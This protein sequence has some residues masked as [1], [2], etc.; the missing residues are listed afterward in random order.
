MKK[1]LLCLFLMSPSLYSNGNFI[2]GVFINPVSRYFDMD[3]EANN[4]DH[5]VL[6]E[7]IED[8]LE[9]LS[10]RIY[11]WK[12]KY[13]PSDIKR[14]IEEEFT[15]TPVAKIKWGD[16]RLQFKDNWVKDYIMYQNVVYTLEDFQK[17]RIKSWKTT[18]VPD[19]Y[20]EGFASLYEEDGKSTSLKE[21]LKDSIKK[22]FQ[23][24]GKGKPRII[25]GQI[26]LEQNPR[27]FL[28]AGQFNTQVNVLIHYKNIEEYKY[29]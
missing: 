10:G 16:Q 5:P 24:R 9:V 6:E 20:G 1:L 13:I 21:A 28:N 4:N 29:H 22:E 17:K 8:I 14:E 2:D 3:I 7:F 26:L 19:S 12:F 11:G 15:L 18:L 23:S 25:E 27:V